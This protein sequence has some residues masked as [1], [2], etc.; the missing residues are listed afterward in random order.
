MRV[1]VATKES[2]GELAGDYSSTVEG[3]LVSPVVLECCSPGTCGCGRGF[4]GLASSQA[5]TTAMVVDR[6]EL[7]RDELW[8]LLY[9]SLE[10]QGWLQHLEPDEIEEVVDEHLE[11]IEIVC[12]SYPVGTIVGRWGTKVWSRAASAAA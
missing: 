9:D 5:T 10:R 12:R 1:L 8:S 7:D 11:C 2:Q 4:P 3:E 6:P